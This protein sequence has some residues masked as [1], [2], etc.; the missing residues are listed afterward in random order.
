MRG[1]QMTLHTTG[2]R[3]LTAEEA[4]AVAGG[5]DRKPG[6]YYWDTNANGKYDADEKM[7]TIEPQLYPVGEE[8]TGGEYDGFYLT[9]AVYLGEAS[10]GGD[11]GAPPSPPELSCLSQ[12]QIDQ[13]SPQERDNYYVAIEAAEIAR[14]ILLQPNHDHYEWASI[15]Y[16]DADGIITHTP[17]HTD[18]SPTGVAPDFAGMT[19]YGQFLGLVHSHPAVTFNITFPDL[20]AYPTGGING[21]WPGFD[22]YTTQMYNSLVNDYGQSHTQATSRVENTHMFIFGATGGIGTNMYDLRNYAFNDRDQI[23]LGQKISLSL[24]LCGS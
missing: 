11:T 14:E 16:R 24:G 1:A 18:H 13:L 10:G 20:K 7:V 5:F 23:T 3:P 8:G 6:K 4:E 17:I 19:N 2:L 21:D 12:S 9:N 22:S 15:I